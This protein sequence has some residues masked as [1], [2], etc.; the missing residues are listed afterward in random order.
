MIATPETKM[1]TKAERKHAALAEYEKIRD[2]A[3]EK[4][5]AASLDAY[6]KIRDPALDTYNKKVK[7]IDDEDCVKNGADL[8]EINRAL[9]SS[10]ARLVEAAKKL[11]KWKNYSENQPERKVAI[12]EICATLAAIEGKEQA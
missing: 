10:Y 3:Y 4:I 1:K 6:K 9:K 11:K 12:E 5:R 8:L 7:E 2:A